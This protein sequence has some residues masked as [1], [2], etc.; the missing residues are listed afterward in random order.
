MRGGRGVRA[1]AGRA[2]RIGKPFSAALLEAESGA[3]K[4]VAEALAGEPQID[5]L[6][7][8]LFRTLL[9]TTEPG[10][11]STLG[12]LGQVA[13]SLWGGG[14]VKLRGGAEVALRDVERVAGA[15]WAT[16]ANSSSRA[17]STARSMV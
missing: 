8:A 15:D 17:G 11:A 12:R 14:R 2:R 13:R 16:A 4:L 3:A 9:R 6:S 5:R 10:A 7:R 1:G